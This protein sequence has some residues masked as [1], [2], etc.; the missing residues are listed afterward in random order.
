LTPEAGRPLS[1]RVS[2]ALRR[3]GRRPWKWGHGNAGY[4]ITKRP[5]YVE[6]RYR[7]RGANGDPRPQEAL[8]V[9]VILMHAGFHVALPSHSL[10][11]FVADDPDVLRYMLGPIPVYWW[12]E[13]GPRS[14]WQGTWSG[15][16][17]SCAVPLGE[18]FLSV[19]PM[20]DD[21]LVERAV[22]MI[23]G[24]MTGTAAAAELGLRPEQLSAR[25]I[26]AG[27]P[28]KSLKERSSAR[29]GSMFSE[30]TEQMLV[31]RKEGQTY[32]QIGERFDISSMRVRQIIRA[33]Q[34]VA[35]G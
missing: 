16:V 33:Q 10:S 35:D 15:T 5:R 9:A 23:K 20:P 25:M 7:G 22:E 1:L 2:F 26:R 3:A 14:A 21:R 17:T 28:I 24:G 19:P 13:P 30:R 4:Q 32:R 18:E 8:L 34:E 27:T 11:L 29:P 31:M 12:P 6:V